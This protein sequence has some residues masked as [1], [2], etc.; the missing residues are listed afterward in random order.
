MELVQVGRALISVAD[1]TLVVKF[2]KELSSMNVEVLST[3]GTAK[4]LK[5]NNIPVM[6]VSEFTGFPEVFDGRV[7]T[8]NPKIF[9]GI[10]FRRGTEDEK[11]MK[12]MGLKAIDLVCVNL[13]EFE[14]TLEKSNEVEEIVENVDIGGPSLVRASAKNYENVAIVTSPSDYEAIISEMKERKGVSLETR[15]KLAYKAFALTAYYDSKIQE[16]FSKLSRNNSDFPET[17]FLS[18]EKQ[19]DLRYG[20]NPHQQAAVYGKN[21]IASL[22]QL[23]GKE[24]SYNNVLDADS[25][26]SL[27]KEFS[28]NACTII[29]HTNPCG[30]AVS[31]TQKE[32]YLKALTCDPQSAFGGIVAFSQKLGKETAEELTRLFL[33]V[34]IAPGFDEEA[35]AVLSQKKNVRVLDSTRLLHEK[36]NFTARSI[37]NG[38][39]YQQADGVLFNEKELRTVTKRNPSREEM[40]DLLFAWKVCKHVKSNAIVFAKNTQTLGVGAGQMSR[41]DSCRI[42][43]EKAKNASFSLEGAVMASDAFFPFRDTVDF[44]AKVGVKAIIQPGGSLKDG[45][46]I[47]AANEAGMAMLFTGMRHFKH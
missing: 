9:A 29:K 35:I 3:G 13:Y 33:E 10:L 5:E 24:L 37:L 17:L 4:L 25:A 11:V 46:S 19:M 42:A 41:I 28:G 45:K 39:L 20:E 40:E 44:A 47:E 22:P 18:Y 14:K 23:Q 26:L 8:L 43:A 30:T 21:T 6:E 31:N 36:Q 12:E 2:A 32:A 38:M 7:K 27:I 16:F 15:K 1:K 34:I